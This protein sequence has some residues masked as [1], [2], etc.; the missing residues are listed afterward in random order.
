MS[1]GGT[2]NEHK[3]EQTFI[4]KE[5]LKWQKQLNAQSVEQR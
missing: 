3:T 5:K 4:R 1:L 2:E